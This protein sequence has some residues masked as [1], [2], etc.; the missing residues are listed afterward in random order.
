[1]VIVIVVDCFANKSNGTAVCANNLALS[2]AQKGHFVRIVAPN[3]NAAPGANPVANR[4]ANLG[5]NRAETPGANL[6][7]SQAANLDANPAANLALKPA[8]NPSANPTPTPHENIAYHEV[9][10]RYIPLVS[11]LAKKQNMGFGR[12][13]EGVLK[14]ALEDAD[15]VHLMLPFGL[16]IAALHV[17]KKMKIPVVSSFHLQPQNLTY[18]AKIAWLPRIHEFIFWLFWQRLY[19]HTDFIHCP[20]QFIKNELKKHGYRARFYVV[21]NGFSPRLQGGARTK[22]DGLFHIV[23]TA[24]YSHEKRQEILIE[25]VRLSKY[26]RQIKLHLKGAGPRENALRRRAKALSN[27]VDFGFAT[28]EE[29]ANL[30]ANADLYAHTSDVD[31]ESIACLEAISCGVVP[32]ISDSA[33]SATRQFALDAKS[34]FRAGDAQDLA[35]KIDYFFENRDVLAVLGEKYRADSQRFALS[36]CTDKILEMYAAARK[37]HRKTP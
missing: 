14:G 20:S 24:R 26:E 34:L 13:D 18:N 3:L 28:Q 25:A 32:I 33:L 10:R 9:P 29:L 19:R 27:A 1:M 8:L 2:L 31:I 35:K 30:Y 4:G 36:R 16:E 5:E 37:A 15:I 12:G 11:E 7:A 22:G 6:A 17:A 21:S 23:M